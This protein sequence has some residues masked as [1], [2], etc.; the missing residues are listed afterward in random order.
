M[1]TSVPGN[2]IEGKKPCPE[3]VQPYFDMRDVYELT[4]QDESVFKGQQLVVPWALRKELMEKPHS[5]HIRIEGCVRRTW[6]TF[7]WPRMTT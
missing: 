6:K 3:S 4:V 5:S 2:L 7:V 1:V